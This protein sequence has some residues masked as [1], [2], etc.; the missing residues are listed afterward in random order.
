MLH[1]TQSDHSNGIRPYIPNVLYALSSHMDVQCTDGY[2]MLLAYVSSYA[3][4]MHDCHAGEALYCSSI[5]ARNAA[6]RYV[7]S[8]HPSEPE[9][10]FLL[11]RLPSAHLSGRHKKF[12][13]PQFNDATENPNIVQYLNRTS[14]ASHLS[15]LD[16]QRQYVTSA[17]PPHP[18]T[19][20]EVAFVGCKMVG[21]TKVEFFWQHTILHVPF[22]SYQSLLPPD[23]AILPPA[24]Q[25]FAVALFSNP[26]LWSDDD[27]VTAFLRKR[28]CKRHILSTF[29]SFLHSNI[30]TLQCLRSGHLSPTQMTFNQVE[31]SLSLRL[32]QDQLQAVH[33]VTASVKKTLEHSNPDVHHIDNGYPLFL[34]K[35]KSPK[36]NARNKQ[37]CAITLLFSGMRGTGKTTVLHA[38]IS[39]LAHLDCSILVA[40]PTG[41]LATT[42]K[43]KFHHAIDCDTVHS[44][45]AISVEDRC[46]TTTNWSLSK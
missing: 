31:S 20:N 10:W 25:P 29:L 21:L 1:H 17:S 42:Y 6:F 9:M 45:F 37:S 35:G 8:L 16:F 19:R 28:G 12:S 27:A 22:T 39:I 32:N 2:G 36:C 41:F 13:V 46:C 18:Y 14:S 43:A 33:H 15:L 7:T 38:I 11:S 26:A 4:K 23:H 24:I 34:I 30:D 40:C 5:D 3:T 44:A